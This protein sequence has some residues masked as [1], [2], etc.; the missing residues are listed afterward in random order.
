M[1]KP[2][3]EQ[4]LNKLV[5]LTYTARGEQYLQ[6]G[7]IISQ[8]DNYIIFRITGIQRPK[9]ITYE[10]IININRAGK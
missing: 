10:R 4:Y 9:K 1:T 2:Q 3:I 7:M 5:Q 6:T 8:T